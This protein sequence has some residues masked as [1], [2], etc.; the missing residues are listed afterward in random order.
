MR[1]FATTIFLLSLFSCGVNEEHSGK[2]D[3]QI[4]R[5]NE[6]RYYGGT[7]RLNETEYI[8]TIF[9]PSIK[10]VV[11]ARVASLFFEGLFEL[12]PANLNVE[13]CLVESY[14]VDSTGTIYTFRL[15]DSIYFHRNAHFKNNE[16]RKLNSDDIRFCIEN[17][18]TKKPYNTG[19]EILLGTL[20]GSESFYEKSENQ[21]QEK[22]LTGFERIDDLSFRLLLE[23]PDVHFLQKLSRH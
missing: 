6:G 8:R 19:Y 14:S 11:S 13:P 15:K 7:F 10:D 18:L 16:P 23:K 5:T 1:L 3:L 4:R 9:P 20:K 2:K 17:L 12:N 22:S 21:N